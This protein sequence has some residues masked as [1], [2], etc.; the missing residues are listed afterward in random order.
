[1]DYFCKKSGKRSIVWEKKQGK[2]HGNQEKLGEKAVKILNIE[3][4]DCRMLP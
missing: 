4:R 1:M 3:W 2:T